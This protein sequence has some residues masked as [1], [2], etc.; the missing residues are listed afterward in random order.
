[1]LPS[2]IP[3]ISMHC[4]QGPYQKPHRVY[5]PGSWYKTPVPKPANLS[6]HPTGPIS[7]LQATN[8]RAEILQPKA[9]LVL[10]Q[11]GRVAHSEPRPGSEIHLCDLRPA[12]GGRL[13]FGGLGF[14]VWGGGGGGRL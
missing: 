5:C 1:M 7:S 13:G 12:A 11:L 14:R 8:P 9:M 4:S 10:I 6:R 2:M 3:Q